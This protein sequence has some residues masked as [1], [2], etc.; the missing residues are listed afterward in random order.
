[1]TLP[2]TAGMWEQGEMKNITK[3]LLRVASDL[4]YCMLLLTLVRLQAAVV[5]SS[6]STPPGKRVGK[7]I[8][9]QKTKPIAIALN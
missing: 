5:S 2:T 4:S 8:S 7:L 3:L 6:C 1:M 9:Y